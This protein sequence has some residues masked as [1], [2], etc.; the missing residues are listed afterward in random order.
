VSCDLCKDVEER[1]DVPHVIHTCEGCGRELRIVKPG[2]HGK[3]L[4]IEK[5]D[6]IVIP[7]EWLQ[8]SFNPLKA[9]GHF[10]RAGLEW[11]ARLIFIDNLPGKESDYN[12]EAH[13]L[14]RRVDS[15]V[16]QSPLI[17]PLDV[18]NEEDVEKIIKILKDN[19]GTLE[20]WAYWTG[21]FLA[22]AREARS[23]GNAE[24]AS[25]ATACAERCHAMLIFKEHLEEVVWMGHSAGRILNVLREWDARRSEGS[26]EFWQDT[27]NEHSYVLSQVFA[28]PVVFIQERAYVGGMKI[29]RQ[30]AKFVDY[31]FSAESSREAILVEIKTPVA[32]LLGKEYRKNIFAPSN[33]LSGSV[34]QVL[35]YRTELLRNLQGVLDSGINIQAFRP[36]C[37]LIIGN[38]SEELVDEYRRASFEAFRSSTDVEIVT[39]DELFRKVEILVELFSLKRDKPKDNENKSSSDK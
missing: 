24:C 13:K 15:I 22:T 30:D 26:E 36:R 12:E 10:T 23:E 1:P 31:L 4:K 25:W 11:F 3:G 2:K 14:E 28:V 33:E 39:Y 9:R 32:K 35:S 21:I 16:N 37:V 7:K 20:Y 38:A 34:V 17:S 19:P 5:G 27:F 6:R 18:N 29:D 8:F